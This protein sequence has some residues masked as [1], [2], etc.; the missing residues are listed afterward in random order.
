MVIE[1]AFKAKET[2]VPPTPPMSEVGTSL[3]GAVTAAPNPFGTQLTLRGLE[4]VTRIQLISA[5]GAVLLSRMHSQD[6]EMVL[7]TANLPSGMYLLRL[8]DEQGRSRTIR[9]VKE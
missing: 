6:P 1:A 9:L 3:L 5:T 8:S 2:P 7:H 4:G